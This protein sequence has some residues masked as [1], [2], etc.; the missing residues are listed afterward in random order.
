VLNGLGLP[1]LLEP[2]S[3]SWAE[4]RDALGQLQP[5]TNKRAV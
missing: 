3:V 2:F 5:P 4:Q 1:R